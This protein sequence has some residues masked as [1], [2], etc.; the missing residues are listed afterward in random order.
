MEIT[1]KIM[2]VL[3]KDISRK[4]T[5]T[6]L[7]SKLKMSRV[8]MWK[9]LKRMET[10]KYINLI[11]VGS[12]TTST[13]IIHLNWDNFLV[14]K[15]LALSLA[16]EA[17]FQRRW[18]TNFAELENKVDFLILF[19]SILHSSKTAGDIDLLG[20]ISSKKNFRKTQKIIDKVQLTLTK[21][22]HLLCFTPSE[23]QQELIKSNSALMDAIATG[24]IL[25]NQENFIKFIKEIKSR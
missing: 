20:I 6:S 23:L 3:L 24:I 1:S 5:V 13:Y 25:Y 17:S 4:Q 8:G 15:S 10:G 19:G 9:V 22:L 7:A 12:G 11:P 21:K 2:L 16:E 14:E 18:R